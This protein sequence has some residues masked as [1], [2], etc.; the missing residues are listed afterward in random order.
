MSESRYF[1]VAAGGVAFKGTVW[2]VIDRQTG[3]DAIELE[4]REVGE[5]R[6]RQL[7]RVLNLNARAGNIPAFEGKGWDRQDADLIAYVECDRPR[8]RAAPGLAG[9]V[10]V[11]GR[12]WECVDVL[13][14]PLPGKPMWIGEPI[15]LVVRELLAE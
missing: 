11:S 5:E 6:A 2:H 4:G 3:Q 9:P 7:A 13:R 14:G 15:G 10:L 8:D 12:Q 1:A